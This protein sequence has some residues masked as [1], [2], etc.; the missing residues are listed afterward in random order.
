[1]MVMNAMGPG[2][3]RGSAPP[4]PV[5]PVSILRVSIVRVPVMPVPETRC[6]LMRAIRLTVRVIDLDRL[7]RA[8]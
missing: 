6:V 1:M 7:L 2:G 4:V 3:G 8:R 5:M